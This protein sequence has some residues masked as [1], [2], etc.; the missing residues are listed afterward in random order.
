MI[1]EHEAELDNLR[2][3]I[4]REREWHPDLRLTAAESRML[5]LLYKR[6]G[7]RKEALASVL[8]GDASS[9]LDSVKTIISRL[10]KKLPPGCG[11]AIVQGFYS[12]TNKPALKPYIV[13]I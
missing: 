10:R 8:T 7:C 6:S 3:A 5:A 12:I 1:C 13:R 11:I 4:T 2:R 9:S